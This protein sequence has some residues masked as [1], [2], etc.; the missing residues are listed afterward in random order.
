MHLNFLFTSTER[1]GNNPD[2]FDKTHGIRHIINCVWD[3]IAV[4]AIIDILEVCSSFYHVG[5]KQYVGRLE[6]T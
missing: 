5:N 6:H 4:D 3:N 2:L 1:I